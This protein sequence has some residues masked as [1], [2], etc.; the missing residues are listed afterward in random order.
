MPLFCNSLG[1]SAV[2]APLVG[3]FG[4]STKES[5]TTRGN[6]SSVKT[7]FKTPQGLV[8]HIIFHSF[9]EIQVFSFLAYI[10]MNFWGSFF[11]Y[12]DAKHFTGH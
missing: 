4:Y 7:D 12:K 3:L 9:S 8:F 5:S 11:C 6:G 1:I 10:D 2:R